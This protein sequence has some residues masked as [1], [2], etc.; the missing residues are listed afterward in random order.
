MKYRLMQ[1]ARRK[2]A[3]APS[4]SDASPTAAI[5]CP[6]GGLLPEQA[7]GA[8]RQLIPERAWEYFYQ[9]AVQVEGADPRGHSP[10]PEDCE[11]C[12]ICQTEFKEVASKQ[13]GLRY[14]PCFPGTHCY[15]V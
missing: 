10:F 14:V 7:P 15:M 6:H 4:E 13:E 8:K 11:S 12:M 2:T 9:N 3:G 1:W 5:R